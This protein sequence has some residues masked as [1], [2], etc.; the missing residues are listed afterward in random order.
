[1]AGSVSTLVAATMQ[2]SG[3]YAQSYI[4][5]LIGASSISALAI[6]I[7]VLGAIGVLISVAVFQNYKMAMW[8][9][10]GPV[11]WDI[12]TNTR[13]E[14]VSVTW[15]YVGKMIASED[16]LNEYSGRADSDAPNL[17]PSTVF[18][19]WDSMVS[20]AVQSVT[21]VLYKVSKDPSTRL[22]ART[23]F[24]NGMMRS[25][26]KTPELRQALKIAMGPQC[27]PTVTLNKL[28]QSSSASSGEISQFKQELVRDLKNRQALNVP[29][30]VV[31]KLCEMVTFYNEWDEPGNFGISYKNINVSHCQTADWGSISVPSAVLGNGNGSGAP[32]NCYDFSR[33]IWKGMLAE[34]EIRRQDLGKSVGINDPKDTSLMADWLKDL[35][36]SGNSMAYQKLLATY[37]LKNEIQRQNFLSPSRNQNQRQGD[38]VDSQNE[39]L[40]PGAVMD[41]ESAKSWAS[42]FV[43]AVP[44]LE[45]ALLYLLAISFPFV[46][47]GSLI[48]GFHTSI[49]TWMGAW[50]WVKS[51]DIGFYVV[52]L[53]SD[54]ASEMMVHRGMLHSSI[55]QN[56]YPGTT[57]ESQNLANDV[58]AIFANV[59]LFQ[60]PLLRLFP[61]LDPVFSAGAIEYIIALMTVAIP[62]MTGMFF[63]YG[64][65]AVLGSVTSPVIDKGMD[66]SRRTQAGIADQWQ[67]AADLKWQTQR[68][69]DGLAGSALGAAAG[70]LL[71]PGFGTMAGAYLGSSVGSSLS[72]IATGKE[73]GAGAARI[74]G[75]AGI[76]KS[77]DVLDPMEFYNV[78][79]SAL[80]VSRFSDELGDMPQ[81]G[82]FMEYQGS[83]MWFRQ[84][85]PELM[86]GLN[87]GGYR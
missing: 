12:I 21:G 23:N 39:V 46:A 52:S 44:F 73:Q 85:Y 26:I 10:M 48:P 49:I 65:A 8:L 19:I 70:T 47:M 3:E 53:L 35:L 34:A 28:G 63:L 60:E 80:V 66:A 6:G 71:F 67:R 20:G 25:F 24:N 75:S 36:S 30:N 1:M 82:P 86:S 78:V 5:D 43:R 50:A 9:L 40:G 15:Q 74:M 51:W 79:G 4:L 72:G 17:G 76:V 22:F 59:D 11:M 69:E 87:L 16:W 41:R 45:G 84:N 56:R 32:N 81:G 29:E 33:A 64:R 7:Y 42:Y 14:K 58:T 27:T 18:K 31:R 57:G 83:K 62:M 38:V 77:G 13:E 2:M 68:R 54:I 37:M 61:E 55:M